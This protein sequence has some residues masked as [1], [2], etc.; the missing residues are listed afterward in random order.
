M[1][2]L[3][4]E[5]GDLEPDEG[6][7]D[8][9]L[10]VETV[11]RHA[12]AL[13]RTARR[14]SLCLD[15]AHDAYQRALE[16]FVR[17]AASLRRE[18]VVSWL[19]TVVKHEAMAVRE[20]R[21]RL[22]AAEE[23]DFDAHACPRDPSPDER[24]VS[25]DRTARAAEA[26][27]RLKPQEVTALWLK[28]QGLSYQRDRRAPVVVLYKGVASELGRGSSCHPPRSPLTV[29][30]DDQCAATRSFA[31]DHH[32]RRRTRRW[33]KPATVDL[34]AGL[35]V[36]AAEAALDPPERLLGLGRRA[37]AGGRGLACLLGGMDVGDAQRQERDAVGAVG[38]SVRTWRATRAGPA[39]SPWRP[40]PSA[41]RRPLPARS[42]SRRAAGRSGSRNA[43][44]P[45]RRARRAASRRTPPDLEAAAQA[46]VA[47]QRG[48]LQGRT[49]RPPATS[50]SGEGEHNRLQH[51]AAATCLP[52]AARARAEATPGRSWRPDR[53]RR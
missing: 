7:R 47:E 9:A 37:L 44:S 15:D 19:H 10:V 4:V 51:S 32:G 3:A 34:A 35:V 43:P 50:Y 36:A 20:Q 26:L 53:A 28:A 48:R 40:A 42:S 38:C 29:Q 46:V 22:V 11:T 18:T 49:R 1:A 41:Q 6:G 5:V 24:V 14:H 13:L 31:S 25:F 2:E 45:G 23:V 39:P 8:D 12:V 30:N 21:A 17:R 27:G 52:T 33:P 16:I